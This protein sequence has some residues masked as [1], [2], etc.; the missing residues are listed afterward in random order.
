MQAFVMP[1]RRAHICFNLSM[2]W[3]IGL[4]DFERLDDYFGELLHMCT[5]S[6]DLILV[7]VFK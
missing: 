1:L 4:W 5:V 3:R 7:P 2:L 6:G